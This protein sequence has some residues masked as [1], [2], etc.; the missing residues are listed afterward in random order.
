MVG[1][2][3]LPCQV[4]D[5]ISASLK[6]GAFEVESIQER[7]CIFIHACELPVLVLMRWSLEDKGL[8]N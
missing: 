7:V 8:L 5:Q 3:V 4:D 2:T 6:T 1:H